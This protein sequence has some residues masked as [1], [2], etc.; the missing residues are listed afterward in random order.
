LP[1][2]GSER[3]D[4]AIRTIGLNRPELLDLY[5]RHVDDHIAPLAARV[6]RAMDA[7][8]GPRLE[9]LWSQDVEGWLKKGRPFAALSYDALDHFFPRT[10]R[11][12]WSLRLPRPN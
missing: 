1:R 10:E 2:E 12:R 8:D 7:G 4:W 11:C 9:E 3:G 5:D 6:E